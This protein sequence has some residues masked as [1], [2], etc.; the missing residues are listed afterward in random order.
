MTSAPGQAD[1]GPSPPLPSSHQTSTTSEPQDSRFYYEFS[2]LVLD[3]L[4]SDRVEDAAGSE[5]QWRTQLQRCV[6]RVVVRNGRSDARFNPALFARL[7]EIER[8][9]YRFRYA[10]HS[11]T[12]RV[13]D[14]H[15]EDEAWSVH[16]VIDKASRSLYV[17][18]IEPDVGCVVSH[19][20][21]EPDELQ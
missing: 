7:Q 12:I 1:D 21:V 13:A 11:E 14:W 3:A 5:V 20:T 8:E 4:A 16:F 9:P 17:L 6:Q 18:A 15:Y 2:K 10:P 19:H